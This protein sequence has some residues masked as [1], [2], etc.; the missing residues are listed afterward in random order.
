MHMYVINC[1]IVY[2]ILLQNRDTPLHLASKV[3]H[4]ELVEILTK[5]GADTTSVNKVSHVLMQ[6]LTVEIILFIHYLCTMYVYV[7]VIIINYPIIATLL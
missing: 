7:I 4:L 2:F 3:D 5:S 1:T 6:Q